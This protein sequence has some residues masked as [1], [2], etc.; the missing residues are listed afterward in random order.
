MGEEPPAAGE[1]LEGP[2]CTMVSSKMWNK[3]LREKQE[4]IITKSRSGGRNCAHG[5]A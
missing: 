4:I 5:E 3:I 2:V 1:Q